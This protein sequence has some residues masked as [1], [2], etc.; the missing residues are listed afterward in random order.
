MAA[1][2]RI[3]TLS[4]AAE[5]IRLSK[6]LQTAAL[7]VGGVA[8]IATGV[9]AAAS[10]GLFGAAGSLSA[11][12]A[13]FISTAAT[14]AKVAGFAAAALMATSSLTA[15]KASSGGSPDQWKADPDA[16]IDIVFGDAY[17]GG[18]IIYRQ[19][20]GSKNK[21]QSIV[22]E[23]SIGPVQSIDTLY[24]DQ[25]ARTLKPGGA[26][27]LGA[28]DY[29]HEAR[30]MGLCPEPAALTV[31]PGQPFGW[32]GQH[33]LSGKAAIIDTF[34]Y[35]ADGKN[36]FTSIPNCG[37][38]GKG[39][40][41]YDPRKDSTY[42][43]GN[44][45]QRV[46]DQATWVWSK[47]PYVVALTWCIG[48][49]QNGKLVAGVGLP[50]SG[51]I[52]E[53]FVEGA[54][55]AEIN[56]WRVGGVKSTTDDKWD[57]LKDIL[58]A[59]AGEPLRLGALLGCIVSTPRVSLATIDRDA[60][61]QGDISIVAMQARR[62][63]INAM[64]PRYWSEQISTDPGTG[65]TTTT[66]AEV[67][68][69]PI[70]VAKYVADDRRQVRKQASYPLVQCF[71]GEQPHQVAT[72]A[73]YDIENSR[74][75]GPITLPLK[76]RWMGYKPGDVVTV[77]LTEAGLIGQNVM[78]LTRSLDA[79]SGVVTVTA[80]SETTE[81]HAF[82]LGQTAVPPTSPSLPA[83]AWEFP[84]PT[85]PSA[86]HNLRSKSV[87]YPINSD[88]DS[89]TIEAFRGTVD[90]GRI[91]D[92]PAGQTDGLASGATWDILWNTTTSAYEVVQ[93]PALTQLAS[94]AYIYID[95]YSTST[96]GVYPALETPPGGYVGG[97]G[98]P[99]V[100]AQ[101]LLANAS[102]TGPGATIAAGEIESGAWVW[103]Q[104]ET[105]GTWGA[106]RVTFTR[107]FDSP[108]VAVSSRPLTSPSHL[109]GGE[110]GWTRSDAIGHPAGT[111]RVVAL[112][113]AE[114][115]TYVLVDD[116]GGWLL[117]HNKRATQDAS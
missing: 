52:L 11:G 64:V 107:V 69:A 41:C 32:T 55:I 61:A 19:A 27:D 6:F 9:G 53:Q 40:L 101:I 91:I 7:V 43:G 44:G 59:G 23:W 102:R 36:T 58:Q 117:S 8:L 34:E 35:D 14:V 20:Y 33:K 49:R 50:A 112:T 25:I 81:K 13:A 15:P 16:G 79:G 54:N 1:I 21:Y 24:V 82:A 113:V 84:M 110:D 114:A 115:H 95:T 108:L 80:R 45:P 37:W 103:S 106:Y 12:T 66:W 99:V 48:W 3:M 111:G 30:Q 75:F 42:P 71:A 76:I 56:G 31:A 29:M 68:A 46:A 4:R 100:T 28:R 17:N 72:L 47:N 89:I 60:L 63:R 92:F 97:G 22:T 62:D 104:H 96:A 73:R 51:L 109:W 98:C 65:R 26:V 39:V 18:H 70:I 78:L 86:A 116:A 90:D 57:V 38:R 83:N 10:I 77:N 88:D 93:S 5:G 105:S 74:E 87:A 2:N 67:A 94:A 85:I